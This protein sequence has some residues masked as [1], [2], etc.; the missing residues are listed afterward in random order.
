[1][2][3]TGFDLIADGIDANL[4][5]LHKQRWT[6]RAA[7]LHA[8]ADRAEDEASGAGEQARRALRDHYAD[9]FRPE[10]SCMELLDQASANYTAQ[11]PK[12]PLVV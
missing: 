7:E 4:D 10:T 12:A 5:H 11:Q 6:Q 3:T 1:M 2:S 8:K 9:R